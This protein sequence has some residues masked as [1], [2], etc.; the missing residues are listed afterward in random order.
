MCVCAF[1]VF[2]DYVFC[3]QDLHTIDLE[4]FRYGGT[5]ITA[6]RLI[7]PENANVQQTIRSWELGEQKLGRRIEFR[8]KVN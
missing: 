4:E 8:N 3:T 2:R 6:F 5:N 1:N 7:D